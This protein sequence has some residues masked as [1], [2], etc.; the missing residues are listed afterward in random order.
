MNRILTAGVCLGLLLFSSSQVMAAAGQNVEIVINNTPVAVQPGD[1]PGIVLS[2]RTYVPLRIV[3]ENLGAR[4]E[5][6]N[7]TK[8]VIIISS[9]NVAPLP[10]RSDGQSK[11]VEIVMDGKVLDIPQDYGKPFIQS[12]RTL[13]PLRAV[14]EALGCQV[15]WDQ[16]RRLV[17]ISSAPEVSQPE[18]EDEPSPE[19]EPAPPVPSQLLR[20]L[21]GYRTNIKLL[22]GRVIS[23]EELLNQDESG[24]SPEQLEQF[25]K[26]AALLSQYSP[27]FKIPGGA[28]WATADLTIMGD[29]VATADQLRAWIAAETPRLKIKMEQ[30][31]GRELV[32]IPD[33][34]ELYIKIGK[35]YG[36]RG[37]LAFCQAAKET[38]YWQFTGD[39]QP[40]QNNY[41]GLWATGAACSGQEPFNG[42]D[43]DGVRF[44]EGVHGAIFATP[45]IGVE[46]HI[47]HLYAY[48]T[49][50]PLPSG[51]ILYDPRFSLVS[52]GIAPT[53]QKLNA[54]WAVPGTT[55]GQSIIFDYWLSAL[56]Y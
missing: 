56:K 50:D 1:Q 23:S 29:P 53:W 14:G 44:E 52:Q 5:F 33:L 54:R 30:Q 39:V 8:Q 10:G 26:A 15:N 12:G 46:A 4:V 28:Q 41:C 25:K 24:F 49:R 36:I 13:I 11:E 32:P 42:A 27:T 47:Q 22:D 45:E 16:Q 20:E 40:D 55:Y 2:G 37:D 35:E 51:K 3:G 18:P 19:I 21:A 38:H 17:E 31:Y 48:A 34:A 43:P 6:I 9:G 7:E